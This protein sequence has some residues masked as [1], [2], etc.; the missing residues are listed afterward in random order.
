M[1]KGQGHENHPIVLGIDLGG[2]NLR[3]AL[4][5]STGKIVAQKKMD[6]GPNRGADSII[7]KIKA[8]KTE[9]EEGAKQKGGGIGVGIAGI[10]SPREGIVFSSPHFPEWKNFA[11]GTILSKDLG[12]PVLVDN[13]VNMTARGEKWMGAGRDWEN[14]IM[15]SLGTGMGG[16]LVIGSRVFTGD[17]GFAG[18]IGHMV[19]EAEGPP[20]ACGSRGCFETF[21]SAVGILRMARE[22]AADSEVPGSSRILELIHEGRD[23]P[24]QLA[25]EA[26]NGNEA[27][28][29]I[30]DR[31]GYYLGIGLA[32]LI[33]VTGI[34]KVVLGGG[35]MGAS[36]LF[37]PSAREELGRRTYQKTN[38]GV[39]IR[40]SQ[41]GD[42][43]GVVGAGLS[44]FENSAET[45]S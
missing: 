18:E 26:K 29:G 45:F 13:D 36:G 28:R 23:L 35:L 30:F 33:N 1:Q 39:E 21:A 9:L 32:S 17:Y 2:T 16:A 8:L 3:T 24:A 4:V 44:A 10:V 43:A 31:M 40:L 11:V 34:P 22:S 42:T 25:A 15:V 27:A 19:C 12:I 7:Q 5:S 38:E 20:C 41:L 37:L 14:F 6:V